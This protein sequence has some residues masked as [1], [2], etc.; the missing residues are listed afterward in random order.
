MTIDSSNSTIDDIRRSEARSEV[1]W[2]LITVTYNSAAKLAEFWRH[3]RLPAGVEWIVVDNASTDN[4]VELARALNARV[5][6]LGKNVGFSAANNVGFHASSGRYVG[7]I[8][9]DASIDFESLPLL[10]SSIESTGGL[11]APQ[12]VNCDGTLQPN[13][14]GYPFLL[15]KVR[16][17]L[18]P[19]ANSSPYRRFAPA[20]ESAPV[21]WF[22]GAVILGRRDQL[23]LLGAWDEHFFLYYEDKDLCLRAA[24]AGIPCTLVGKTKWVHGWARA[25]TK[26]DISAWKRELPSMLKFY[27]R[28]PRLLSPFTRRTA[29]YLDKTGWPRG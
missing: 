3:S 9:P 16:N 19:N 15:D 11:V 12:L 20:G 23:E 5:I 6:E 25:T 17:R 28:Y 14:R 27:L 22:I 29:S 1:K 8:N 26:L 7:F 13:G 2:S 18:Q 24:K 10:A 21:V 4:S